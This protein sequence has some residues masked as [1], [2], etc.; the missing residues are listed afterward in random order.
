MI[1]IYQPQG[2]AR[3]YSPLALNIYKGCDHNCFY[4]YVPD[5]LSRFQPDYNHRTVEQRLNVLNDLRKSA[6]KYYNTEFQVLL[7]FTSDP[8]CSY[9]DVVKLT[10]SAL[11]ILLENRIP[12]AILSKGGKRV[13]QDLDLFKEFKENI[14]VG[15]TL[16]FDNDRDSL[17]YESGAAVFTERIETLAILDENGITTWVSIE[18]VINPYMSLNCIE[19]SLPFTSHYKIGKLNHY[20]DIESKIDWGMF[21]NDSVEIMR[22]NNKEFYIKEDLRKHNKYFVTKLYENEID[23]DYLNVKQFTEI[24]TATLF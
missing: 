8:Y 14:K 4:C 6:K 24:K 10:R 12:V 19:L 17:M 9:N 23:M 20:P 18:P 11:E 21:L 15:T 5:M 3:E 1:T 7:S 22:R 13:L 16:T 2:K